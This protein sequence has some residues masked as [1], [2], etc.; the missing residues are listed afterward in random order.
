[1]CHML[2]DTEE[3]LHAAAESLGIDRKHFQNERY[4]HYD[5]CK[6]K[7]ALAVKLGAKEVGRKEFVAIARKQSI[8]R[9]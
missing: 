5:I 4:P 6:S 9:E 7:R 2:A 1:M 8:M 3:E